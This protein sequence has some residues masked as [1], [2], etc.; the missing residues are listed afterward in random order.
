MFFLLFGLRTRDEP[1]DSRVLTC[2]I[3]G[4]NAPQTR[5]ARTTRF[6]L[7]FIPLFPVKPRK[8]LLRC[9]HCMGVR[10]HRPVLA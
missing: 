9:A 3:C 4:W 7:F 10:E 5:F 6:T 2:E 1:V 8:Y